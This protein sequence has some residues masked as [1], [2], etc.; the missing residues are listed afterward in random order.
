MTDHL[1]SQSTA[2]CVRNIIPPYVVAEGAGVGRFVQW[3]TDVEFQR[4]FIQQYESQ[5]TTGPSGYLLHQPRCRGEAA[6]VKNPCHL[7]RDLH[8][9][10]VS[11]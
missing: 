5:Q 3:D 4:S 8:A 11:S 1:D 6:V 10:P 7:R 2:R 9:I